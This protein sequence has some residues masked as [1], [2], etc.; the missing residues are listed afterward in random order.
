[1]R[2]AAAGAAIALCL[3]ACSSSSNLA[4]APR[5]VTVTPAVTPT[6]PPP[7]SSPTVAPTSGPTPTP[8]PVP[9]PKG[10]ITD[11]G[12]P[13]QI[14]ASLP[15]STIVMTPCGRV[16]EISGGAPLHDITVVLDPGHGGPIDTGAV[17]P[18]GLVERDL[19]L[20]LSFAVQAELETR[21]IS[22]ALTR[23]D[24]Y[25]TILATRAAFADA[26]G[27]EAL[28][29]IHHNAPNAFAS[30]VPGTEIF[31]QSDAP[32]SRRLGEALYASVVDALATLDGVAWTA[33]DDAGVLR[34]LSSEGND[35]YGMIRRP[36]TPT[37]LIE[38]GY[39]SN[40]SE[41]ALF[42]TPDYIDLAAVAV[43][44]GIEAFLGAR[45]GGRGWIAEPRVF[46]PDR[47]PGQDVCQDPALDAEDLAE[48]E[49]T[50]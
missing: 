43:A 45:T 37:A 47:A 17:G 20:E 8:T 50:E 42:A 36:S 40:P 7:T 13:V 24:D 28:V 15:D 11:T 22:V 48:L 26:L 32:A 27:A 16:A 3:S 49:T 21:G 4:S 9:E 38:L 46:D 44:D 1:M 14:L 41:A 31:V 30:D 10:L 18:N 34:V 39:I 19:N 23:T 29:S 12:V 6:S 2:V 5:Q 33:A 25:A 35:A